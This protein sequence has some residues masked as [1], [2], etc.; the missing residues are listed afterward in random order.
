M[1]YPPF[2]QPNNNDMNYPLFKQPNNNT[3]NRFEKIKNSLEKTKNE[4]QKLTISEKILK[5]FLNSVMS[6]FGIMTVKQNHVVIYYTFGKYDGYKTSG[7]RWISPISRRVNVFCGDM[8]ITHKKMHLTDSS[9]N[10]IVISSYVI[11][12]IINPVNYNCNLQSQL[13]LSNW[14]ENIV[15]RVISKYSY[16]ELTSSGE[17]INLM[18]EIVCEINN[19]VEAEFYGINVK[20]A[21]ILEINYA[22]EIAEVMLVKQKA[23]AIIEARKELVDSTINLIGDIGEKLNDKLTHEDKS[24]LITCLTVS[25]IGNQSPSQVI[26]L[27]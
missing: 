19:D 7:L 6:P 1:N 22:P 5:Y 3:E 21:G 13:V 4:S 9:S 2:K 20:K 8:T 18:D 23:K 25:M 12:S 24:K 17:K 26:N 10:P 14:I 15:R 16:G 27:N 11:Y